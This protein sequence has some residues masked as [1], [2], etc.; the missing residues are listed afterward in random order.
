MSQGILDSYCHVS[1][2]K[3]RYHLEVKDSTHILTYVVTWYWKRNTMT[4]ISEQ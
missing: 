1:I 4:F 2:H 3:Y